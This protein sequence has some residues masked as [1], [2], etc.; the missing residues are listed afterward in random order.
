MYVT[1]T[2]FGKWQ[3]SNVSRLLRILKNHV[4]LLFIMMYNIISYLNQGWSEKYDEEIPE[5]SPRFSAL[6]FYTERTDI[7]KYNK[8]CKNPFLKNLLIVNSFED[9][10][11][12]MDKL[13][14]IKDDETSSSE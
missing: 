2:M 9:K 12:G 5:T 3:P 6:G 14:Y 1:P 8:R 13:L 4:S 10:L 7:P 11:K